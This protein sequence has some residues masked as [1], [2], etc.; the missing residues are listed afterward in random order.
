MMHMENFV[1]PGT[2]APAE[3]VAKSGMSWFIGVLLFIAGLVVGGAVIWFYAQPLAA[4]E[5]VE[6]PSPTPSPTATVTPEGQLSYT[7]DRY[8][9]RLALPESWR[10]L[11]YSVGESEDL[12]GTS[13]E[14]ISFLIRNPKPAFREEEEWS[15]FWI[16]I[17]THEGWALY[18]TKDLPQ[19][20]GV[21]GQSGLHVFTWRRALDVPIGISDSLGS[22]FDFG[23]DDIRDS[24][25]VIR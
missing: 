11:D 14:T 3:P 7:N 22:D 15:P 13:L 4:P 5:A 18:Q 1:S 25:E 17:W 20:S 12:S 24:F 10:E 9:F 2:P 21:L 23:L 8:G 16:T 19:P 6:S